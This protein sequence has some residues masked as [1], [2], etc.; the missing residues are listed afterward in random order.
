MFT[1]CVRQ[2]FRRSFATSARR[3][4]KQD[5]GLKTVHILLSDQS[6][7]QDLK[8]QQQQQRDNSSFH[9]FHSDQFLHPGSLSYKACTSTRPPRS[10][11][12][13]APSPAVARQKDIFHQ[14]NLDPRDFTT[15]RAIL[16]EFVTEMGKIKSRSQ[17]Q[18]SVKTQRLLGRTIRRSKMMG[19]IPTLSK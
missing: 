18:L 8:K 17:T 12:N 9:M 6:K 5:D 15:N 11:L 2:T 13:V 4:N 7:K 3:Q 1:A 19:I 16:Y 14:L 10:R